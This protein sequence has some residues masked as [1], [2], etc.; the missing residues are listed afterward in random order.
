MRTLVTGARGLL[1]AAVV[2]EFSDAGEVVALDREALDLTDSRR[3]ERTVAET[4]PDVIVNC[5]AYNHVDRAEED[6]LSALALNT[7]AVAA[8]AR[9]ARA[10]GAVLV[11]YGTDFVFDGT[12]D[13][14][15]SE[16]DEPNPRSVYAASKLAGEWLALDAPGAFVLRVE[17]LFGPAVASGRTGSLALIV[18]RIRDGA[19]LPVFVDRTVSPGYT[20]DIARAT[21]QL[22]E[23]RHAPGVYHC[24]NSGAATWAEIATE[25]AR[26]LGRPANLQ[27]MTL[28]T[29][30]LAA[31][32]PKYSALSTRKLASLGIVM[33]SWQD[34]LSR[35]LL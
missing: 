10:A 24:V 31:A 29:A 19:P 12:A 28:E 25:I 30:G 32:R 15:Y 7:I 13:R 26:L 27:P 33:P 3:V 21:R 6:A 5:A 4:K 11:H 1:A 22:V 18:Q 35:H 9:A 20:P 17:S 8:L 16:D 23:G 14:P 2:R 34:A